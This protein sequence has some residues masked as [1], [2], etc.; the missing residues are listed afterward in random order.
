MAPSRRITVD[1]EIDQRILNSLRRQNRPQSLGIDRDRFFCTMAIEYSGQ[2]PFSSQPTYSVAAFPRAPVCHKPH[3][4]QV[5]S[6][7]QLH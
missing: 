2:L 5:S 4:F 1:K 6:P 3:R 7:C